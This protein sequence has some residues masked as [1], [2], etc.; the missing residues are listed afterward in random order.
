LLALLLRAVRTGR[1]AS[2]KHVLQ[3]GEIASRLLDDAAMSEPAVD[4]ANLVAHLRL[5]ALRSGRAGPALVARSFLLR[6]RALDR[7][8]DSRLV[9]FLVG[10]TLLRLSEIHLARGGLHSR[11]RC[12]RAP[13][14]GSAC[15][16]HA[17]DAPHSTWATT[18]IRSFDEERWFK[19]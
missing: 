19:D 18:A 5:R 4:V 7:E 3:A 14:E 13:N 17:A 15:R 1:P 6:S 16:R 2:A 8:L 10:T 12:S 11:P 9:T